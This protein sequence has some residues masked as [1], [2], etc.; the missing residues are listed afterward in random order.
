MLALPS[1]FFFP[2]TCLLLPFWVGSL[3]HWHV[4]WTRLLLAVPSYR[5]F[6]CHIP[7]VPTASVFDNALDTLT[8]GSALMSGVMKRFL[9]FMAVYLLKPQWRSWSLRQFDLSHTAKLCWLLWHLLNLY[10]N[11]QILFKLGM[12]CFREMSILLLHHLPL[13]D[14]LKKKTNSWP[15]F[16]PVFAVTFSNPSEEEGEDI[17]WEIGNDWTLLGP[18]A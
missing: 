8:V 12:K 9:T 14:S 5:A 13:R 1:C 11:C 18:K 2:S 6:S 7:L 10:G 3:S 16:N 17:Y 15:I 4:M